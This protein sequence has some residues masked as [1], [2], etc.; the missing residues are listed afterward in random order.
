MSISCS[1]NEKLDIVVLE[2]SRDA[3]FVTRQKKEKTD[4]SMTSLVSWVRL[5]D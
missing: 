3:I 4:I 1:Q 5:G 2:V